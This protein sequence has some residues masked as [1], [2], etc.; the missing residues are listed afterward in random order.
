MWGRGG[1]KGAGEGEG[2]AM[3]LKEG[4]RG[5]SGGGNQP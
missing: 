4:G 5:S 2:G 3:E 1:D